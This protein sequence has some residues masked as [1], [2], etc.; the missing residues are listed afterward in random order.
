MTP[1]E[2]AIWAQANDPSFLLKIRDA[3]WAQAIEAVIITI[4]RSTATVPAV[5]RE[6]VA[7]IRA[8]RPLVVWAE[9]EEQQLRNE[10]AHLTFCLN[11]RDDFLGSIGQ[12]EA[13]TAT[14]P[15][16]KADVSGG[17]SDKSTSPLSA[18]E[19]AGAPSEEDV[20]RAIAEWWDE[21]RRGILVKSEVFGLARK[22]M[23]LY[24]PGAKE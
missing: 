18:S 20:A 11:S 2:H 7:E 12:W 21:T 16:G 5:K 1:T 23:A 8:L 9:S 22:L 10:V 13:Y 14:L 24:R 3:A 4:N 6:L 19:P 15:K 17:W